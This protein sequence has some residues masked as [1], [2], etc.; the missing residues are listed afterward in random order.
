MGY[1]WMT[2]TCAPAVLLQI[3]GIQIT[4]SMKFSNHFSFGPRALG[5][6]CP[7]GWDWPKRQR[8]ALRRR[9]RQRED[10]RINL[11]QCWLPIILVTS[12]NWKGRER[13]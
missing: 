5:A 6:P 11:G 1:G 12:C 4:S 8:P 9:Y 3:D 13:F 10:M 2:E 7:N